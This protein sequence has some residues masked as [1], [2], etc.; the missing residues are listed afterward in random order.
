MTTNFKKLPSQLSMS[1]GHYQKVISQVS[2][3]S[4]ILLDVAELLAT[5]L[6]SLKGRKLFPKINE[7]IS[8]KI[9][10]ELICNIRFLHEKASPYQ[11]V[12]SSSLVCHL[13]TKSL[14]TKKV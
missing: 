13:F 2:S 3:L 9:L 6:D 7:K 10:N 14:E 12:Q 4:S 5:F 8:N 1:G 11:K